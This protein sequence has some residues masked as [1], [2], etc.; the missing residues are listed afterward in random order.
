MIPAILKIG[1]MPTRHY[2]VWG[3]KN[4]ADYK[5]GDKIKFVEQKKNIL[6]FWE[7]GIVTDMVSAV[8]FIERM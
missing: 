1:T 5:P 4:I 3:N 2:W 6:R 7:S 8:P